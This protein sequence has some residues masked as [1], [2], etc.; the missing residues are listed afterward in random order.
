MKEVKMMMKLRMAVTGTLTKTK[1]NTLTPPSVLPLNEKGL[2][3]SNL[4]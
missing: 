3:P 2:L 1:P 4:F